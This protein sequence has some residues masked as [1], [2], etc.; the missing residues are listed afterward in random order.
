MSDEVYCKEFVKSCQMCWTG[1]QFCNYG[2][3][4]KEMAERIKEEKKMESK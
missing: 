4:P 3:I 2:Y 1:C